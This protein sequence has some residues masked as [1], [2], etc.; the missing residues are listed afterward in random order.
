MTPTAYQSLAVHVRSI[1]LRDAY[2]AF[3][4][5]CIAECDRKHSPEEV[6]AA[7]AHLR[8]PIAGA[9]LDLLLGKS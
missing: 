5:D 8:Q 9:Q 3:L 4:A 7:E 2:L 6:A 1:A